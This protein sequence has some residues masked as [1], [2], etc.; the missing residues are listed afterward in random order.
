MYLPPPNM[1]KAK[2]T[3]EKSII[4]VG[5]IQFT[6]NLLV[7][8]LNILDVND[9]KLKFLVDCYKQEILADLLLT[10]M[11]MSLELTQPLLLGK[12]LYFSEAQMI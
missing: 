12:V 3:E 5:G 6:V 4:Y 7:V 11:A 9:S 8:A 2:R 10:L 1:K